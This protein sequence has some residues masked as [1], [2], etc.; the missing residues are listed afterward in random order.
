MI[1]SK[2][3]RKMTRRVEPNPTINMKRDTLMA[4]W[5]IGDDTSLG[6][7]DDLLAKVGV[8]VLWRC[9]S[10]TLCWCDVCDSATLWWGD[11]VG[12]WWD[13]G[14]L[15]WWC[16]SVI[17]WRCG[18]VTLLWCLIGIVWYCGSVMLWSCDIVEVWCGSVTLLS[19]G[20][21]I[22]RCFGDVTLSLIDVVVVWRCGSGP[23]CNACWWRGTTGTDNAFLNIERD[24]FGLPVTRSS[25]Q[26]TLAGPEP[27][28]IKLF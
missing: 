12:V 2:V 14:T 24:P 22:V 13:A 16:D 8:V 23:C 4:C 6:L 11:A 27:N 3:A 28:V 15:W 19:C 25:C 10:V 18:S 26:A 7:Q 5:P 17:M 1:L 21:G 9:G 20:I